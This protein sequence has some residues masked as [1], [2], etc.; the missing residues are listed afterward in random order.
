MDSKIAFVFPG[1]GSQKIGMLSALAEKFDIVTST[2]ADASDVL[3]YD[4]WDLAQNGTQEDIT[5]TEYTQPL[6]L[7]VSVV[8]WRVWIQEGG[9]KPA[10]MLGHSMGE[11][12]ALVCAG[13]VEFKDAVRL[14]R[15]RGAYM[16]EIGEGSMAA[17]I[18]LDSDTVK[19]ICADACQGEEVT[20]V[21][22]NSPGQAVIAG[23]SLAVERAIKGCKEAGAKR[24]FHLPVSAPFHTNLMQPV[25]DRLAVDIM[26]TKF[27]NPEIPVVHN[28]NAQTEDDP[29]RIKQLMIEQICS[30][31]LWVD[32]V[33]TLTYNGVTSIVEC[34]A[35]RVLSRLCKRIDSTLE[36][37]QIKGV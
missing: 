1:Q 7:T 4:L 30:P 31:I 21:N 23:K 11:W 5:K 8:M 28:V 3:G 10:F 37:Y 14:V 20:A 19:S 34:G 15:N 33:K 26:S 13:V 17:V 32:C 25:A 12:S 2:F 24:I 9:T 36:I 6:L 35:G 16:Q 18:G 29:E 27:Y 22:F